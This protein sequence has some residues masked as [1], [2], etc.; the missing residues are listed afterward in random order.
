MVWVSVHY[1]SGLTVIGEVVDFGDFGE[2]SKQIFGDGNF[3][4]ERMREHC[5][6]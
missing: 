5:S 3:Q 4:E 1:G 6:G 2:R